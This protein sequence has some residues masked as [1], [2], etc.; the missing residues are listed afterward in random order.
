MNSI[1]C[2]AFLIALLVSA[3]VTDAAPTRDVVPGNDRFVEEML[4]ALRRR[5]AVSILH[6]YGEG[7]ASAHISQ[8]VVT[9]LTRN[10]R[11]QRLRL[12]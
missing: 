3:T 8:T 9:P 12:G 10:D 1:L 7:R 4:M 6:K 11:K 5:Q 2:V